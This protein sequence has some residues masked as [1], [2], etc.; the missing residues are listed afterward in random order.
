MR[1]AP[2]RSAGFSQRM[3]EAMPGETHARACLLDH[4]AELC[5]ALDELLKDAQVTVEVPEGALGR[6]MP[7]VAFSN[8][9]PARARCWP[10]DAA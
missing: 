8:V 4:A 2:G 5:D 1:L 6:R 9:P 10:V 7:S 3:L